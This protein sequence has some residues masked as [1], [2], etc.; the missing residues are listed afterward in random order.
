[1]S[2]ALIFACGVLVGVVLGFSL[3]ALL[4]A[5]IMDKDL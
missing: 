5:N 3:L 2:F 4:I 1:M